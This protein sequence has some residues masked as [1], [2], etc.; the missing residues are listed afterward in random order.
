M[1]A[2]RIR[3][4]TILVALA[5]VAAGLF[6]GQRL[7]KQST[8]V[9]AYF[10]S[11]VGLYP[12]SDVQVLG[13]PVGTVTAVEPEGDQIKVIMELDPDQKVAADTAAVIIAPTLVSDRFVQLTEPWTSG[14]SLADGT[15]IKQ[16]AVPVEIDEMY[17]SL[18]DIGTQMGPK[19][20][21]RNG[22]LSKFLNVLAANLD[23]QGGDI[24]KMV[25][26]FG[27]ASSTI[28]GFDSDFF[29]TVRNL[30][31]LNTTLLAHDKGVASANR[32]MA[33]VSRYLAGD[34]QNLATAIRDLGR[35]LAVLEDF[36]KENRGELK[37]SVDTLRG[38][39]QLL[40]N[41]RKSL[42]EAVR[43]VP[44]ALQNFIN[45]YDVKTNTMGGRGNLNELTVWSD[46]GKTAK[47]SEDAPPVLLPGLDGEE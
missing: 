31:S 3:W 39:T 42:D 21:N 41:Q 32:Q 10:D 13:V 16:T 18:T 43:M 47:S 27:K 44:L 6:V 15:E 24:N 11:A 23:G 37:K 4:V 2:L 30:D 28:S 40:V 8:E 29:A 46:N 45:A 22:A 12:G 36:V 19:G 9:T 5:I 20:A 34:R 35:A 1:K 38:P 14:P 26:E 7:L 17:E 33:V 25:T